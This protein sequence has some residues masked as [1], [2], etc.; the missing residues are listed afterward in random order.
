MGISGRKKE[1]WRRGFQRKKFTMEMEDGCE[2]R[3]RN[4]NWNWNWK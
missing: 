1:V 4:G 2:N 3:N